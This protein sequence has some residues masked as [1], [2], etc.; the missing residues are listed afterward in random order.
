VSLAL[1][2]SLLEAPPWGSPRSLSPLPAGVEGAE[3]VVVGAGLAG[4][5]VAAELLTRRPGA[6]VLVLDAVGAGGGASGRSTGMLTPG[7]GQD[8]VGQRRRWGA[9][10]TRAVY[11]LTLDAIQ[12]A[13]SWIEREGIECELSLGGQL[14]VARGRRGRHRVARTARVLAELGLPL[15]VLDD[16]GL[17]GRLRLPPDLRAPGLGPAALRLPVAGTLHPL[18]LASALADR[19]AARGGR[20]AQARVARLHNGSLELSDGRRLAADRAVLA[21]GGLAERL[22]VLRGRVLPLRLRALVSEPLSTSAQEALGWSAGQGVIDSRR[23][24]DYFRLTPDRRLVFGGGRPGLGPA[25][26][27]LTRSE[28]HALGLAFRRLFPHGRAPGVARSWAGTIG[29]TLDGVPALGPLPGLPRVL[30]VGGWCGH[31][32]ALSLAAGRWAADLLA[33]VSPPPAPWLR[34]SPPLLPSRPLRWLGCHSV[35]SLMSLG[36]RL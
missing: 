13:V 23:L 9:R 1:Q 8:L 36:D 28:D 30:H 31:G 15:E 35:L 4:L 6:D 33:G 19:V 14:I 17:A 26:A 20:L 12:A 11:A 22:G 21:V 27:D 7:V 16:A 32:I 25:H 18:K 29:Y 2:P 10:R 3:I 5:S 24:F 34:S